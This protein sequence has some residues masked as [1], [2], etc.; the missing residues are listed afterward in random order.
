MYTEVLIHHYENP[1]YFCFDILCNDEPIMDDPDLED[2]N[3][4]E[5]VHDFLNYITDDIQ[6]FQEGPPNKHLIYTA[7]GDFHFQ[8]SK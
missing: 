8:V 3:V 1:A 5:R 6:K 7:G 2:Y 4:E